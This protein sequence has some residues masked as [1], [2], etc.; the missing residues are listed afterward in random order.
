MAILGALG[1]AIIFPIVAWCVFSLMWL[2]R[3]RQYDGP[4]P[5]ELAGCVFAPG[6]ALVALVVIIVAAIGSCSTGP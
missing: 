1:F 2:G 5:S 3:S 4:A 6:C